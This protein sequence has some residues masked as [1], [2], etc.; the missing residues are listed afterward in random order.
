MAGKDSLDRIAKVIRKE[1]GNP[2]LYDHYLVNIKRL[3]VLGIE[4]FQEIF[5]RYLNSDARKE[6]ESSLKNPEGISK[7]LHATDSNFIENIE[8]YIEPPRNCCG[9]HNIVHRF[10]RSTQEDVSDLI[11]TKIINSLYK[12]VVI[13]F[14]QNGYSQRILMGSWH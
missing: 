1:V 6:K 11:R 2:L 10:E 4:R 8:F 13:N 9:Y 12:G 7:I 5:E 3:E 14:H